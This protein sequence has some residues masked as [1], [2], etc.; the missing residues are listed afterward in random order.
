MIYLDNAATSWPKPDRV[1]RAMERFLLE[2]GGNPGRSGHRRALESERAVREARAR[3][4]RLIGAESP[5][6][7]V[8][9]LNGTDALNIAIHGL[10]LQPGAHVV[11]SELEHNSVARPLSSLQRRGVSVS[12]ARANGA[13]IVE[14][15]EILRLIGPGT[16]LLALTHCSNVIG[17]VAPAEEYGRIA[18]DRGILFLLDAAQ[19]AGVVELDVR[20]IGADLVAFPGHKNLLG[21][22]GTGVL[23]VRPG[24]D[25]NP[26]REGG[27]GVDSASQSHPGSMP[28]R[29]EAGTA[30]AIG[31]AGL[32]AGLAFLEE[33]GVGK[34]REH[35]NRLALR[36]IERVRENPRVKVHSGKR[37]EEQIGPV[38]VSLAG[39][40]PEEV[41]ALLDEKYGIACRAGLHCAPGAHRHLG[42]FPEGCLRFSF[43]IFNT[44]EE[45]DAA[46]R[47]VEELSIGLGSGPRL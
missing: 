31:L 9:T 6:R 42:T 7:V 26:L 39:G 46:A 11:T 40:S 18:R 32:A 14:P 36:F 44:Q 17:E 34:I 27:T 13:G 29:L 45:A 16:K 41:G 43:G 15:D 2:A 23:Y 38:S 1:I 20:K 47:A 22:M 4:A 3:A 24:L 8:F 19:T 28:F 21:P 10:D 12:P 37:P 35:E 5:E 33:R 30:N 25:L